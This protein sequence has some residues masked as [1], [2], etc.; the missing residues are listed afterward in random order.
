MV[1]SVMYAPPSVCVMNIRILC[2]RPD[3]CIEEALLTDFYGLGN[4]H[5]ELAKPFEVHTW[6]TLLHITGTVN[7]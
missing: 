5:P 7:P 1:K 3:S 2:S 6:L 4:K